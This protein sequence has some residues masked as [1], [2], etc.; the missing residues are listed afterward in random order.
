MV[1]ST[2]TCR[3]RARL[4]ASSWNRSITKSGYTPLSAMCRQRNSSNREAVHD[5]I[6]ASPAALERCPQTP[7]DLPPSAQN[8]SSFGGGLSRLRAIPVAGSALG[9]R[10]RRALSS[11]RVLPGGRPQLR[12]PIILQRAAIIPL[13]LCLTSGVHFKRQDFPASRHS[14]EISQNREIPTFLQLRRRGGGKGDTFYRGLTLE[15][16]QGGRK[17]LGGFGMLIAKNLVD[18]V[19]YNQ[20]GDEVILVEY[21]D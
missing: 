19:I 13:A 9:L 4:S 5:P 20:K 10:P 14:L 8:V 17:R 21:L 3:K 1:T 15:D 6:N 16:L 12:R 7:G 2:A 11:A 18:E